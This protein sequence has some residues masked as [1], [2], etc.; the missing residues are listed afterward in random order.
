MSNE[1]CQQWA[2]I[3]KLFTFTMS[4]SELIS[5][6]ARAHSMTFIADKQTTQKKTTADCADG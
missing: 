2:C 6:L 4:L 5:K 1:S 3:N